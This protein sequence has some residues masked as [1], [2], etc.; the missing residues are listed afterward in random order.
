MPGRP[1]LGITGPN[2][3]P[4]LRGGSGKR[5]A[6]A[7]N[8]KPRSPYVRFGRNFASTGPNNSI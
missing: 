6:A 5:E 2:R 3:N 4:G 8:G 1:G 7:E